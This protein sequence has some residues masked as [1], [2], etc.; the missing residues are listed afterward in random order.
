MSKAKTYIQQIILNS[1]IVTG[2]DFAS[3]EV[4][5]EDVVHWLSLLAIGKANDL[6]YL[7][8]WDYRCDFLED[9]GGGEDPKDFVEADFR[10]D[11]SRVVVMVFQQAIKF[12]GY[13][14]HEG[15]ETEWNTEPLS[16]SVLCEGL[17]IVPEQGL[18]DK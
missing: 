2:V 14:R 11:S 15:P 9:Q 16:L 3:F 6:A 17:G 10:Q 7:E 5:K 12:T 8:A 18:L 4:S 1:D 13:K